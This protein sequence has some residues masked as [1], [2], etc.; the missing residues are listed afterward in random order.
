LLTG[1]VTD[2]THQSKGVDKPGQRRYDCPQ[3][4]NEPT[5]STGNRFYFYYYFPRPG[6]GCFA[7][8]QG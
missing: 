8:D 5:I 3:L 2:D 4:M 7:L 1:D 6:D